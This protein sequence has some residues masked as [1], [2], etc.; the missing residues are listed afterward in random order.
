[1]L[2][3]RRLS[4]VERALE[5]PRERPRETRRVGLSEYPEVLTHRSYQ[6]HPAHPGK[7]VLKNPLKNSL[8]NPRKLTM[9]VAELFPLLRAF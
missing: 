8:K 2:R 1:M 6:L 9:A 4:D 3:K 5:R 7:N